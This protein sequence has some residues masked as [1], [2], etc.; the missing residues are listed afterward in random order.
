MRSPQL[1]RDLRHSLKYLK[2]FP[3][4]SMRLLSKWPTYI[5]CRQSDRCRKL[6]PEARNCAVQQTQSQGQG[7]SLVTL[8]VRSV[9]AVRS[10]HAP[11]L[12]I[13]P[14]ITIATAARCS[15]GVASLI[16]YPVVTTVLSRII[17][18][19]SPDSS[20]NHKVLDT[21]SGEQTR[22]K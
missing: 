17:L 10:R 15:V 20:E 7:T 1:S 4:V 14:T 19:R 8:F 22:G 5:E 13:T 11:S 21:M 12:S 6:H 2:C 16:A 3:L 18:C 9:E